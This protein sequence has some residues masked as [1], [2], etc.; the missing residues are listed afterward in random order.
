[1]D[2]RQRGL[3]ITLLGGSAMVA[4]AIGIFII[5]RSRMVGTGANAGA[6][7]APPRLSMQEERGIARRYGLAILGLGAVLAVLDFAGV[8]LSPVLVAILFSLVVAFLVA[9]HNYV[10]DRRAARYDRAPVSDARAARSE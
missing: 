7:V 5:A 2:V 1:M 6:D 9:H 8:V 3:V 4:V 10:G